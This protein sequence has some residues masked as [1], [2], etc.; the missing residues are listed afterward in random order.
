[1]SGPYK[2][3]DE[4]WVKKYMEVF[5]DDPETTPNLKDF[6]ALVQMGI[7]DGDQRSFQVIVEN[8]K[9]VY[10]GPILEGKKPDFII[11]TSIENWRKIGEKKLGVKSAVVTRKLKIQGSI[12]V[13]MKYLKG[14]TGALQVFGKIDTD[15]N[16]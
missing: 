7:T 14:L 3:M 2:L 1:M 13:A 5:N 9:I 12:P 15:W 4:N 8:G 11:N 16:V 6:S 10:S